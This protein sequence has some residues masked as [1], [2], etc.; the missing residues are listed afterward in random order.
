M[1]D[2]HSAV[3]FPKIPFGL[4][5]GIHRII[6]SGVCD[7]KVNSR[8]LQA[9][10]LDIFEILVRSEIVFR[11]QRSSNRA[12]VSAPMRD[13]APFDQVERTLK[14]THAKTF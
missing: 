8:W 9:W 2:A 7:G 5:S 1:K 13:Q 11:I 12:S 6:E 10:D 4:D 14:R 3:S